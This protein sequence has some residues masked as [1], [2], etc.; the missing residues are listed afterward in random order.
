MSRV[1]V[2]HLTYSHQAWEVGS[3]AFVIHWM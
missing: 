3:E 1:E 2:L